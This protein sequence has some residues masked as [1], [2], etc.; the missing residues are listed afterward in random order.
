MFADIVYALNRAGAMFVA[1]LI[2]TAVIVCI[3]ALIA[4]IA[5]R[6]KGWSAAT[7][8]CLWWMSLAFVLLMPVISCLPIETHTQ[9]VSAAI[10][11][12]GS[13]PQVL[14]PD[15]SI[16]ASQLPEVGHVSSTAIQLSGAAAFLLCWF[17]AAGVQSIRVIWSLLCGRRLKRMS[18][19]AGSDLESR[20]RELCA[21][22]RPSRP[23]LISISTKLS[24]PAVIG[25]MR[26]HVI[27]PADLADCLTHEEAEQVLL[28]ELAHM[29]RYDDILIAIQRVLEAIAIFHPLIRY[30]GHRLD[31]DREMAC[32]DYVASIHESK[33]YAACLARVAEIKPMQT[34]RIM[35]VPF[36][37]RESELLTRV[38]VLLDKTRTHV[39]RISRRRLALASAACIAFGLIGLQT[40]RLLALPVSQSAGNSVQASSP[41]APVE[42]SP[43]KPASAD[44]Q[45]A[46]AVVSTGGSD[47]TSILVT[48]P[49]GHRAEFGEISDTHSTAP[50]HEPG[51]IEFTSRG[52]TYVIRDKGVLAQAQQILTP[53]A[54][55]GR[56]QRALGEQQAK[57]GA[58]QAKY[59][60]AQRK[61]TNKRLDASAQERLSQ[62]LVQLKAKLN[63]LSSKKLTGTASEA[64]EQLGEL[65]ARLAG[66][67]AQMA[68][69]QARIG[70]QQAQLGAQQARLGRQQ[71]E[72][73]KRQAALGAQQAAEA[74][75][76]EKK[77][78]ELIRRAQSRGLAQEL[79]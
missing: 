63:E 9:S 58:A 55:L 72:L 66:M 79:Q 18:V 29:A 31:L 46:V 53:S 20:F 22:V 15:S 16:P 6:C 25:Y 2:N 51:A 5:A 21:R 28:H 26:P 34:A 14:P 52:D 24:S 13:I 49:T 69:V 44:S 7:R 23:T 57:L 38:R 40:P 59:G 47:I 45:P 35:L 42:A 68:S 1:G 32:D 70:Q 30:L 19:P 60:E 64:Q 37:D 65:Q 4:V 36:L 48:T 11:D 74:K 41:T 10:T 77:L 39:P 71:G 67:Q 12:F 8:C 3:G 76:A 75:R 61:V 50:G 56:M 54:E 33:R 43:T 62:K 17:L 27:L 78:K 73:G